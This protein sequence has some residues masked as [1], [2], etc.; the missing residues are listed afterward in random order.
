VVLNT[1][2]RGE[3]V[4][5]ATFAGD[6]PEIAGIGKDNMGPAQGWILRQQVGFGIAGSEAHRPKSDNKVRCKAIHGRGSYLWMRV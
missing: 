4:R 6:A 5:I 1:F 3:M 2:A